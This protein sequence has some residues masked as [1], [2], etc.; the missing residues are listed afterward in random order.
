MQGKESMDMG[1]DLGLPLARTHLSLWPLPVRQEQQQEQARGKQAQAGKQLIAF[2]D[3]YGEY[4]ARVLAYLRFRVG[5]SEVAE[6]LVSQV[7]ERVLTHLDGLQA[8][9]AVG[10]WLFRIA[11]NCATDY[12][13]RQHAAASLD[14]LVDSS[15]PRDCS[16]EETL[17][18]QEERQRLLALLER[19]PER[20]REVIG[21]KFVACL[22]NREIA[23]VLNMPEGT[24]GSI[25]YRTLARLR[26]G[27]REDEGR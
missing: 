20:E 18:A 1:S 12:F 15:H 27:L 9:G 17:L 14:T 7:F 10:A 21:L 5:S 6:D 2:D 22:Q 25:L 3:L 24:V 4:Y 19:L 16:P 13:R 26:T 23:R 11:R 8:P